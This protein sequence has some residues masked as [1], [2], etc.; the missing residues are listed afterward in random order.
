MGR[1][2]SPERAEEM[3][4]VHVLDPT[5]PVRAGPALGQ[6]LAVIGGIGQQQA[7]PIGK[8]LHLTRDVAE[9]L[10][11][12]GDGVEP[13]LRFRPVSVRRVVVL[14][15]VNADEVVLIGRDQLERLFADLC[16]VGGGETFS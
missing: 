14:E 13:L 12:E 4:D 2:S 15:R 10:R 9:H 1:A 7:V 6:V 5:A 11:L 8:G 16:G 3:H